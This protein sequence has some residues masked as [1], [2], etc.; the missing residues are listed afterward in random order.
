MHNPSKFDPLNDPKGIRQIVSHFRHTI[1]HK[2]S[3]SAGSCVT[4]CH[5][6]KCRN[7][8]KSVTIGT[9]AATVAHCLF[10][11]D[12]NTC[13]YA[14]MYKLRSHFHFLFIW[15]QYFCC[16]L[17]YFYFFSISL[18]KHFIKNVGFKYILLYPIDHSC[19]LFCNAQ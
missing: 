4:R 7:T 18:A 5:A 13:P 17:L 16:N 12:L 9:L 6:L 14:T 11:F 15:G 3:R 10:N 19:I 1:R 8:C 2:K